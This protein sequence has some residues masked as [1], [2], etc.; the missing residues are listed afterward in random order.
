MLSKK[1]IQQLNSHINVEFYSSNLYLQMSAW[2]EVKGLDGCAAFLRAHAQEELA[3]MHRLF[4]YVH[5]TGALPLLGDIKAPPSEFASVGDVFRQV[6]EHEQHITSRIN[7]LV[8]SAIGESD[9]STVNFL[10][11]YVSEQ[12]EEEHTIQ[13]ILDKIEIIGEDGS[14]VFFIDRAIGGMAGGGK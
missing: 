1:M 9:H 2:C 7:E 10:Q 13:Q 11:W 4:K 12:H 6:F 5:E 8:S 14:G 3:H